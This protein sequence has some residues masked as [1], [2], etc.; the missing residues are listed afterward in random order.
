VRIYLQ[1]ISFFTAL[2]VFVA[3]SILYLSSC[4]TPYPATRALDK[5]T[6]QY[7]TDADTIYIQYYKDGTWHCEYQNGMKGTILIDQKSNLY[8]LML[9]KDIDT[10]YS[11][12]IYVR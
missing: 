3:I 9:V 1:L 12:I 7:D 4:N 2:F 5:I 11:K 8:R 10:S 6:V